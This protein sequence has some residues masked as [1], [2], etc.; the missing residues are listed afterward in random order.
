MEFASEVGSTQ[1]GV[2]AT[3]DWASLAILPRRT[4]ELTGLRYCKITT[5]LLA[6]LM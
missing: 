3:Q 1:D 2:G 6:T 4:P 5:V